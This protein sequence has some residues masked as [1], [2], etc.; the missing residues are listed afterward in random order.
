MEEPRLLG[1]LPARS[2]W[3][4]PECLSLCDGMSRLSVC[5][6]PACQPSVR[7]EGVNESSRP[8]PHRTL[9]PL[10]L[11][12]LRLA[13]PSDPNCGQRL[14]RSRDSPRNRCGDPVL[15]GQ[16]HAIRAMADPPRH[17]TAHI[18]GIAID[19]GRLEAY[20]LVEPAVVPKRPQFGLTSPEKRAVDCCYTRGCRRQA[21]SHWPESC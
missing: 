21:G 6:L 19:N 7:M 3:R 1:S 15:V 16:H 9:F 18:Q 20:G 13:S 12:L 2:I 17:C 14:S 5:R 4:V 10:P 11:R 8:P